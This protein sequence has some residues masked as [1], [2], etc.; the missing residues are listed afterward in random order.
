MS[1]TRGQ[2]IEKG[3]IAC[4]LRWWRLLSTNAAARLWAAPIAWTSPVRWRLKSSIGMIWLWPPPAAPPLIPNT[5]PSDGWRIVTAA[6]LPIR[7]S[8]WARPTVVVDLP[9]PSGVGV[10]ALTRMYLPRGFSASSRSIAPSPT[11]ALSGP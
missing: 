5:G 8:P 7:L 4:G 6:R 3:S 2:V 1:T 10:I 11:L 9:S